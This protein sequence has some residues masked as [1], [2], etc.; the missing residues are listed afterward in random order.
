MVGKDL[1][2]ITISCN[3]QNSE[4]NTKIKSER[5]AAISSTHLCGYMLKINVY[6]SEKKILTLFLAGNILKSECFY[7]YFNDWSRFDFSAS[8]DFMKNI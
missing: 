8:K 1:R 6:K 2:N 5:L 3:S 7:N 4:R